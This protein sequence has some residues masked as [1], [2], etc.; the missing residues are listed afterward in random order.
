MAASTLPKPG[1]TYGPCLEPCQHKDCAGRR[2]MAASLCRFCG[3][4]IGYETEFYDDGS[5]HP[6]LSL[7]HARCFERDIEAGRRAEAAEK[8]E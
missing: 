4:A 5:G 3:T 2:G 8:E 7:V 1:T 6:L